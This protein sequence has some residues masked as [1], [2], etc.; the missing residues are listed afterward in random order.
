MFCRIRPESLS[1]LLFVSL[2]TCIAAVSCAA[3]EQVESGAEEVG[4]QAGEPAA[5]TGGAAG[6]I[7]GIGAAGSGQV[8]D[9][10][11]G[12]TAADQAVCADQQV[13]FS[14]INPWVILVIDGSGSMSETF[15]GAASRWAALRTALLDDDQGLV[16]RLQGIVHFGMVLF[17]AGGESTVVSPSGTSPS[18]TA[19]QCPRLVPVEPLINNLEAIEQ[20]YPERPPGGWSP[21]TAA[22]EQAFALMPDPGQAGETDLGPR[23]LVLC[24]DGEPTACPDTAE[25][26]TD[27]PALDLE[28]AARA[29]IDG[30]DR[31]IRTYVV[32]LAGEGPDLQQY[33]DRLAENG[34]TGSPAAFPSTAEELGR[35]LFEIANGAL[36]CTVR[37]NGSVEPGRECE[38]ELMLNGKKLECGNADG[39]KLADARHVELRGDACQQ[40]NH[41]PASILQAAFPCG[42]FTPE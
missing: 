25:A 42:L 35:K 39:W 23:Y 8:F 32:N 22:M 10:E 36:G 27:T 20:S 31:G 19:D 13:R 1:I 18:P 3:E 41:N 6:T 5:G 11:G 33:L 12:S 7:D 24:T 16:S 38:G 17:S 30:T 34:S 37:L 2:L 15:P 28:G 14:R 26:V 9:A 21:T 40:F 4:G 29:V